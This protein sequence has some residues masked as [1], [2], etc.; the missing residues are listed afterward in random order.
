MTTLHPSTTWLQTDVPRVAPAT[1][2]WAIPVGCALVACVV[3]FNE[4]V[5]RVADVENFSFDW[6]VANRL[7][8]CL[9]C[10]CYGIA[11][12]QQTARLLFQI[13]G[14]WGLMLAVWSCLT[15]PFAIEIPHALAGCL[16]LC[17]MV[18]F[19]PA[20]LQ[21]IGPLRLV[22]SSLFGLLAFLLGSWI[23]FYVYP[24]LGT[25]YEKIE[26]GGIVERFGGLNH[27]NALGRLAALT[28]AHL[29]YLGMQQHVR[30]S[31]LIPFILFALAT[32]AATGSRTAVAISLAIILFSIYRWIP[33]SALLMVACMAV[34]AIAFLFV[35]I[36]L[37]DI[38]DLDVEQL[39]TGIS[40][41]GDSEEI[42]S[43]TGRD[44]IWGY[45]WHNILDKPFFGHGFANGRFVMMHYEPMPTHHAHNQ[46]LNVILCTGFVGGL[47]LCLAFLH[48]VLLVF[49]RPSMFPDFVLAVILLGGVSEKVMLGPIPDS[50]TLLWLVSLVWRQVETADHSSNQLEQRDYT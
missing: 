49:A 25:F 30:W 40:R 16:T 50:L 2:R 3:F 10:G 44:E 26:G 28:V 45:V 4:A 36:L 38:V 24:E 15:I 29:M 5:L 19:A 43:L 46:I 34:A 14:A 12:R 48:Q 31:R 9:A 21:N 41:S 39:L 47:I 18:L 6:Q 1:K 17:C 11:F 13:P 33:V 23:A 42:Y 32:G 20:V 27:P 8:I 22:Y 35:G 7:L 37:F